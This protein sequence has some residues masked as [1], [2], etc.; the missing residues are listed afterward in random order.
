MLID[1]A[2]SP[3]C[4]MIPA[5]RRSERIR[6]VLE[7]E[8]QPLVL[9]RVR[10]VLCLGIATIAL[11]MPFDV[12]LGQEGLSALVVLKLGGM[13][14]Y[15]LAALGLG[16]LR[17]STW[18]W[19]I[20]GAT[21]S[22]GLICALNASIAILTGDVLMAAYVLTVLTVGGAIVFAWG[23]RAQLVLVGLATL[24][25]LATLHVHSDILTRSPNLMVAVLSAFGA[26]V[27]VA[28]TLESQRLDR[29]GV[30]LLQAGQKRVLELIIRDATFTELLDTLL[31]TLEEQSPGMLC[32]ILL[33]DEDGRRLRH[34]MSRRLPEEYNRAVD[35]I[36]IGP[37]VG[38]CG[39]AAFHRARV[40][41][42]DV[43]VDPRWTEFRALART[44]GLRAG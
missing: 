1:I 36:A 22:V 25:L 13:A 10:A 42:P 14:A 33:V 3:R 40:I 23:A 43:T 39:T 8:A 37:D 24:G 18:R 5:L 29:K 34:A 16:V 9:G 44:H 31:A 19:A 12:R 15:G 17:R 2:R 11:S 26:S 4:L 27:Y 41:T 7:E 21:A 6:A 20:V 28:A 30:E 35:G 32:S 38:S